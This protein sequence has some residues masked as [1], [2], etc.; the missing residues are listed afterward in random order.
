MSR[1]YS[2]QF[3]LSLHKKNPKNIGVRLA[4][5]CVRT[6]LPSQY[7][8]KIFGVSRMTIYSWFRGGQANHKNITRIKYFIELVEQDLKS[9]VFRPGNKEAAKTYLNTNIEPNLI[10]VLKGYVFYP[11]NKEKENQK[12]DSEEETIFIKDI[13]E[14]IQ[15][16]DLTTFE[17]GSTYDGEWKD[18]KQHGQGINT[19][20]DGSTYDGEWQN[21]QRHGKGVLTTADGEIRKGERKDGI[22]RKK[23][24]LIDHVKA[25]IVDHIIKKYHEANE[26]R[27]VYSYEYGV[28]LY[29]YEI[30]SEYK[31]ILMKK[32][33]A[34]L[35]EELDEIQSDICILENQRREE[36]FGD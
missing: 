22:L 19:W 1:P 7:V 15:P 20:V 6:N 23:A 33:E 3:R 4:K 26:F 16:S 36:E 13:A 25:E 28:Y 12:K 9:G 17:N 32:T 24:E 29:E 11:G 18:G 21:G 35:N 10:R 14:P 8:A 31:K 30:S 34:E 5:L 27:S 2:D